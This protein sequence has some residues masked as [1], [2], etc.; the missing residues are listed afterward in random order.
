MKPQYLVQLM[1]KEDKIVSLLWIKNLE[2]LHTFLQHVDDEVYVVG[3][4]TATEILPEWKEFCK[5]ETQLET[6]GN[7]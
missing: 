2:E 1:H 7:K 5:K 3:D 4:I 6:G